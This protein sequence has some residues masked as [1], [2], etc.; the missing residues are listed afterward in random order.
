MH[1]TGALRH[2]ADRRRDDTALVFGQQRWT[3]S[4]F[5]NRVARRAS[6]L[7]TP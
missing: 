5:E 6:V 3:W 1:L 2:A 4:Q 7:R